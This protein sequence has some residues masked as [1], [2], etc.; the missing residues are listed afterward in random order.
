MGWNETDAEHSRH[1]RE[2]LRSLLAPVP[3]ESGP[4]GDWTVLRRGRS[5]GG[6]NRRAAA[7]R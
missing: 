3:I 2:L 1:L 5:P 4:L 7:R 6:G